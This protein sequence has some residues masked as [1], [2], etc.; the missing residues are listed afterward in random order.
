MEWVWFELATKEWHLLGLSF[1]IELYRHYLHLVQLHSDDYHRNYFF[2][3]IMSQLILEG[4]VQNQLWDL[5][6]LTFFEFLWNT[7]VFSDV[8]SHYFKMLNI[9]QGKSCIQKQI[10]G[11]NFNVLLVTGKHFK[12]CIIFHPEML[13]AMFPQLAISWY[14]FFT[15]PLIYPVHWFNPSFPYQNLLLGNVSGSNSVHYVT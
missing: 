2:H 13:L 11:P 9:T 1:I 10:L 3:L 7:F 8:S 12:L 4:D 14:P 6:F 5:G 15:N